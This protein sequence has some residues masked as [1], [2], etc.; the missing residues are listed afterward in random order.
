MKQDDVFPYNNDKNH[1]NLQMFSNKICCQNSNNEYIW[2][3]DKVDKIIET[4]K[5]TY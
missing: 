2:I 3:M 4:K 5:V 1:E